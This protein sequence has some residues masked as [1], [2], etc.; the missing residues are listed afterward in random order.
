[1]RFFDWLKRGIDRVAGIMQ[2]KFYD[3]EYSAMYTYMQLWDAYYQN[4]ADSLFSLATNDEAYKNATVTYPAMYRVSDKIAK[5]VFSELPRFTFDSK[6]QERVDY[7]INQNGLFDKLR[8]GQTEICALGNVY[9]KINIDEDKDYPVIEVVRALDAAPAYVDWGRITEAT[10]YALKSKD[11][12]TYWWLAQTYTE[13]NGKKVIESKL[14]KGDSVNLG[15]EMPLTT[16]EE[17]ADISPVTDL[18]TKSSWFVHVK[19]PMPNNK[20]THSPLGMSVAANSLEQI[21]HIN[22]TMQSYYRDDKIKQPKA[23]VS[24]DLITTRKRGGKIEHGVDYDEEFYIVLNSDPNGDKLYKTIDLPSKQAD[25]EESIQGK[26]DRFY[27]S[28][29]LFRSSI[30][31]NSGAKTATEW[32]LADKDSTDTG[33]DFKNAWLC[34][35]DELFHAILEIDNVYY[36]DAGV[37]DKTKHKPDQNITIEFMDSVKYNQQEK[38]E[39]S[40]GLYNDGMISLYTALQEIYPDW[41]DDR[42]KEEIA[43]KNAEAANKAKVSEVDFFG[44]REGE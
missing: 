31:K 16:I 17:T 20:D 12:N 2:N 42:I 32:E 19:S 33:A 15:Q 24:E 26:L 37:T 29:G 27:E 22:L 6:S 34:A 38:A 4:K 43:R 25:F 13:N 23:A 10:F 28:C 21:D 8:S 41:D 35:L 7:I 14:Y 30:Q 3:D 39:T 36:Q 11:G 5:L 9:L 1:M 18:K 40:K 44:S